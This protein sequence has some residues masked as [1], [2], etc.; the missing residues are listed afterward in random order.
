MAETTKDIKKKEV[1]TPDRV[2]H[3]RSRRLYTPD[4][5]I[6]EKNDEIVLIADMPGVEEKS[7]D[8]TLEKNVLTIHGC[9]E[10]EVPENLKLT[11]SE[12]GVGDYERAFTIS[13]EIDRE[14]IQ[15]TVKNGVLRLILPKAEAARARKIE[16]KAEA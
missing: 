11:E 14:K 9:V 1:K 8:I 16:V 12:Y 15:A 13:D 4:V 7:V 6:I 5:D 3:T 10:P 2:E